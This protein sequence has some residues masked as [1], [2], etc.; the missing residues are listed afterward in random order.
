MNIIENKFTVG[1]FVKGTSRGADYYKNCD[2]SLLK[3]EVTKIQKLSVATMLFIKVL[4]HRNPKLIGNSYKVNALRMDKIPNMEGFVYDC[5][6]V[7]SKK[8][9]TIKI[10]G[11]LYTKDINA[12]LLEDNWYSIDSPDVLYDA[13]NDSYMIKNTPGLLSGFV[14]KDKKGIFMENAPY[15]CSR[16]GSIY[17]MTS[18]IAEEMGYHVSKFD[19]YVYG[20][21]EEAP[22]AKI[23]YAEK[24]NFKNPHKSVTKSYPFSSKYS[25]P[26]KEFDKMKLGEDSITFNTTSGFKA[27]FGVELETSRGY[28]PKHVVKE[29]GLN[30]KCTRDGSITG[31]EYVTGIYKGDMGFQNLYKTVFEL[32]ER[33]TVDNKTGIHVHIGGIK[34]DKEFIVFAYMLGLIMEN[35]IQSMLPSTRRGDSNEKWGTREDGRTFKDLCSN[36]PRLN[37]EDIST[38]KRDMTYDH[39]NMLIEKEYDKIYG[40]YGGESRN[41]APIGGRHPLMIGGGH[42]WMKGRYHWLNLVPAMFTGVR[43]DDY[44]NPK[45]TYT[46]Q[47]IEFRNHPGSLNYDKIKAWIL[48][49]MAF[50]KFVQEHKE[51]ILNAFQTGRV[52]PLDEIIDNMF[53]FNKPKA[54]SLKEY[55]QNRKDKFVRKSIKSYSKE[56]VTNSKK[57]LIEICV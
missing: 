51:N 57:S 53:K 10:K 22:K 55:V 4:E 38:Y 25:K 15:V 34:Y 27:T 13:W 41:K 36:L 32:S 6:G 56:D 16:N 31:G 39:Y 50:T 12:F 47:T 21:K 7:L 48:I 17:F 5:K 30:I 9:D 45:T 52:I 40:V 11:E 49:C 29:K 46:G 28:L 23:A 44:E 35:E 3:A 2:T 37:F 8:E 19:G 42:R 54:Q 18:Q 24:F 14:S 20:S 43:S 33:C 1:D 26:L